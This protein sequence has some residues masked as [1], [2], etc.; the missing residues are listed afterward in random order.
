[1]HLKLFAD[2]FGFSDTAVQE[3]F[4]LDGDEPQQSR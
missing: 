2:K 4:A 1:M 3:H